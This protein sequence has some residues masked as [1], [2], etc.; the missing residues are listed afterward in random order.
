[1]LPLLGGASVVDVELEAAELSDV[2]A[3]PS[4]ATSSAEEDGVV[5]VLLLPDFLVGLINRLRTALPTLAEADSGSLRLNGRLTLDSPGER[6]KHNKSRE[7]I[8]LIF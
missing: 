8:D 4:K 3:S 2:S 5:V 7:I 6:M 1:M